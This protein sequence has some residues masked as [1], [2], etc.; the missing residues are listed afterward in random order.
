MKAACPTTRREFLAEG[1]ALTVAGLTATAEALAAQGAAAVR[2]VDT[3]TH[4]YDPTRPGGVPWPAAGSPLYRRVLPADWRAAAEPLGVLE[5]VV[6]EA[7]KLLE[8]NDW[9]L[10]L[11]AQDKS[12]IGFVGHLRPEEAEFPERLRRLA[13]NPLLRGLRIPA[14]SLRADAPAF[15]RGLIL[16]ADLGLELDWNGPPAL[17][18]KVAELAADVSALRVVINHVGSA[19]DPTRL[20]EEWRQ[21]MRALGR[22]K[23]VFC[24]VS[25]LTEQTERSTRQRGDAPRDPAYYAPILDHCWD[26]FGEDRLVYG[27]NWPVCE[28]GGSYADQFA[29]V[30]AY[31]AANGAAA[32][33]K[34]FW[35]NSRAAYRWRERA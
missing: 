23:N 11:A 10:E 5:T 16:M 24:K 21:G 17:H 6:V 31:F 34:Y 1:L 15:R 35:K 4:F 22:Q 14:E 19:G 18:A 32:S 33:E 3:H 8:D 9:V 27:S 20:S 12:I 7:S 29:V 28:K 26:C 25:A 2:V 13:M 30:R